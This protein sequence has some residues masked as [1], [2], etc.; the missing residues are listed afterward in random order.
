[1]KEKVIVYCSLDMMLKVKYDGITYNINVNRELCVIDLFKV[2]KEKF[3]I[4]D[5]K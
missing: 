4:P 2:F 3:K 5:E 1:M